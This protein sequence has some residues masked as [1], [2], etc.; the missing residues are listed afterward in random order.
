MPCP[1]EFLGGRVR[2][3]SPT[4]QVQT[5]CC[6]SAVWRK[7]VAQ[8]KKCLDDQDKLCKRA[9]VPK[10]ADAANATSRL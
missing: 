8:L 7:V 4:R 9:L 3:L 6:I 5:T 2:V 1:E 10:H